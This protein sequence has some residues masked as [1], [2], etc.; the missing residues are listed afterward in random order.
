[1]RDLR[2][3]FLP[4]YR[5]N[6]Y[7]TLLED[8]LSHLGVRIGRF[9]QTVA[10]IVWGLARFRPQIVHL[11]WLDAFFTARFKPLAVIKLMSFFALISTLRLLG[12]KIVWTVHN[13]KDHEDR[14]PALDA[15]CTSFVAGRAD[16]I[17]VH[18]ESAGRALTDRLQWQDSDKVVV[19][20]HG[21][22]IDAYENRISRSEA[23][24]TLGIDND[25]L[26]LL[27]FG[28]IRPY[29][30]VLE[31]IDAF[32]TLDHAGVDLWIVGKPR[33]AAAS[34]LIEQRTA[35]HPRITYRPGFVPDE[36]I[37]TYMNAADVVVCPYRDILTSGAV[38]LAMSFG[39]ACL[40]PRIGCVAD[41]LDDDGALLYDREDTDGLKG[42]LERALA[43]RADLPA[44]GNRNRER[45]APWDWDR[46]AQMTLDVYRRCMDS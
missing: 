10:S 28:Q 40:A 22:Y 41:V 32:T 17:I 19:I 29:K 33:D 35:R 1:M 12:C 3:I 24:R 23:R 14:Y 36:E 20:P 21:H 44:M 26:V 39:R 9:S 45:I 42:A 2:V 18:G 11:H 46:V 5:G 15:R 34:D 6:P 38:V 30:G 7:Q 37:Q 13:L 16:A 43:R 31:L 25:R 4:R 27:F 8:H